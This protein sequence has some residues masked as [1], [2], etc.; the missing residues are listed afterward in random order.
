MIW[1][2]FSVYS[3][4]Q[5]SLV[6]FGRACSP[7]ASLAFNFNFVS[8]WSALIRDG[9]ICPTHGY[10]VQPDPN[11]AGFT[12][13]VKQMGRV[14]VLIKN[15][16]QIWLRFGYYANPARTRPSYI[17]NIKK[18]IKNPNPKYKYNLN[19]FFISQL[20]HSHSHK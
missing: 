16:K 18:K 13:P 12:Q 5:L 7:K 19:S 14:W 1:T 6:F 3:S 15:P 8:S 17:Y 11:R 2:T 20:S 9:K 4:L 10:L